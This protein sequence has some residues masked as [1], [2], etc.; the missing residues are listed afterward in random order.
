MANTLKE[1]QQAHQ[2]LLNHV[3]ELEKKLTDKEKTEENLK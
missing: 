3:A 2:E 1:Q